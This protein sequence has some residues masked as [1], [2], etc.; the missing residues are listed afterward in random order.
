MRYLLTALCFS[1]LT[2]S[3]LAHPGS[4]HDVHG[5]SAYVR[6]LLD[7]PF[8]TALFAGIVLSVF[9]AVLYLFFARKTQD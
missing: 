9:A 4:H 7:S 3:A 2:S 8:H 1:L 6:H 5:L